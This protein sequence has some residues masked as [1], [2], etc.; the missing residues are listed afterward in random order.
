VGSASL[1]SLNPQLTTLN[2][3]SPQLS[4]AFRQKLGNGSLLHER[5]LARQAN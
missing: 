5:Q 3:F 4:T 2:L 1:L